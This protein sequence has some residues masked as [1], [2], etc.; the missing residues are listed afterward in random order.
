M[1]LD[2]SNAEWISRCR[3]VLVRPHFAGNLGAVARSMRNFGLR[4]LVL[5]SPYTRPD[6]PEARQRA[7]E[8]MNILDSCRIVEELGEALTGSVYTLATSSLAEGPF[9]EVCVGL[10]EELLGVMARQL[11]LGPTALVFG[12]EPHGLSNAEITR[13]HGLLRIPVDASYP[14]LNLAH[15]V[16]VCLYELRRQ[17][18]RVSR[19]LRGGSPGAKLASHEELERLFEHLQEAL[20]AIH[21]LYGTKA[22]PLMHAMRHLISR[23]LPTP[24]EV[25]MLHGLARQMLYVARRG[26]GEASEGAD[27]PAVSDERGDGEPVAD[28]LPPRG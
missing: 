18:S 25:R 19:E 24:Q 15:A 17:V 4:E 6:H 8:G 16:T 27:L 28:D 5:V 26:S 11:P 9:R 23:A 14:S 20:E 7:R 13:C 2:E 22:G 21:Y 1:V 12:P 3:V 10:P